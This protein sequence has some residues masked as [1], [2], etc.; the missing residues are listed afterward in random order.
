MYRSDLYHPGSEIADELKSHYQRLHHVPFPGFVAAE[1]FPELKA[2]VDRLLEQSRRRDFLMEC[3]D[4]SPRRMNVVNGH[5]IERLSTL[6]P[7]IYNDQRIIDFLSHVVGE[8]VLPL[9]DDIDRYVI[10]QLRKSSDTF[11]AHYDDYPLSFVLIMESPGIEGGGYA[12]MVPNGALS[13]L[14]VN[15]IKLPLKAADAYLLKTDTT[16][17]RV[18]PLKVDVLRT[19]INLAYTTENFVPRAITESANKLYAEE[20]A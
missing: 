11:G 14:D 1:F 6:I 4:N 5:T 2:E 18:A 3:M 16:A 15:P 10:N 7:Q 8:K 9:T 13:D 12:E 17:H 19:A 20:E